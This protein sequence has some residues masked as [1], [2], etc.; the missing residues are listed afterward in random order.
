[1][2][3]PYSSRIVI[4]TALS[5]CLL[6]Y[7]GRCDGRLMVHFFDVGQGDSILITQGCNQLLIDGGPDGSVLHKIG[8]AMPFFD[9]TLEYVLLTHDHSDHIRGL[10][11]VIPRYRTRRFLMTGL[12]GESAERESLSRILDR[13][14]TPIQTV[15]AGDIVMFGDGHHL[16]ILWP[17]AGFIAD[18]NVARDRRH[19]TVN[20][21]S[22]V[23]SLHRTGSLYVS[24]EDFSAE[25]ALAMFT[26]DISQ[27]IERRLMDGAVP[28]R[29]VLLKV[30]HHG[31]SES[32]SAAFVS[33]VRPAAAIVSVGRNRYGHPSVSVVRRLE[34][35]GSV[36][37]TTGDHGD[38]RAVFDGDRPVRLQVRGAF[39]WRD[40][41]TGDLA[42]SGP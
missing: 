21:S 22:I 25:P 13:T 29:S 4:L 16:R 5:S 12:S 33:A 26:G 2:R 23:M 39:G 40:L 8:K 19:G 37:L 10:L 20:D 7:H 6:L 36:V 14:G 18:R 34:S 17:A 15:A 41:P 28:G 3:I 42:A 27:D 24:D 1:M 9:R 35:C 30:A 32:T 38:I 11:Q 31:S